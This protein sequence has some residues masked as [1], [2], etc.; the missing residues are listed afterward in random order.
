MGACVTV[1]TL[2]FLTIAIVFGC[3]KLPKSYPFLACLGQAVVASKALHTLMDR[4]HLCQF[5]LPSPGPNLPNGNLQQAD[6]AAWFEAGRA[7]LPKVQKELTKSC[8]LGLEVTGVCELSGQLLATL[9]QRCI[10]AVLC[11]LVSRRPTA[12]PSA[13]C[14]G[15][16]GGYHHCASPC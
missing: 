5:A 15:H 3:L 6:A 16:A 11:R 12:M 14:A 9:R 10:L 2:R 4:R 8:R 13:G 7:S 1:A